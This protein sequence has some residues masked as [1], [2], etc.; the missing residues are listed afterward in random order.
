M[1]APAD[2][3]FGGSAPIRSFRG[4]M[5][6]GVL[7]VANWTWPLVTLDIHQSG[8]ELR[9][10]YPRLPFFIP[11]LRFRYDDI[12][13]VEPMRGARNARLISRKG[14]RIIFTCYERAELLRVMK[15][16]G[17]VLVKEQ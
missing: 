8:I 2:A 13:A 3:D 16:Q 7:Q 15:M 12:A 10:S 14:D 5:R 4:G 17:G 1:T 11:K 6:Y 9:P